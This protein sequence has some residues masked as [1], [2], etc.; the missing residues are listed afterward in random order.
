[1]RRLT[2]DELPP[3]PIGTVITNPTVRYALMDVTHEAEDH[4]LRLS[5]NAHVVVPA[6]YDGR[7]YEVLISSDERGNPRTSTIVS[8]VTNPASVRR[9]LLSYEVVNGDVQ[10]VVTTLAPT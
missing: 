9:Y 4:V 5:P 10:L 6:V 8:D 1:M 7:E 3:L 2:P